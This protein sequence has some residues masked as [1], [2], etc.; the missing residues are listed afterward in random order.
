MFKHSDKIVLGVDVGGS[1]ISSALVNVKGEVLLETLCKKTVN[2]QVKNSKIIIDQW[3]QTIEETL[4]HLKEKELRGIGVAMPGPFDYENGISLFDGVGKYESLYGINI[5][6]VISNRLNLPAN[7]PLV[8]R[9]DADCFGLGEATTGEGASYKNIIAITLGTGFG[10]AFI[11]E[12]K[13]VKQGSSV[14]EKGYLYN[15]PYKDGIA[16]DYVSARW[17]IKKYLGLSIST[18]VT[19]EVKEIANA[20]IMHNDFHA[21]EVFEIYGKSIAHCLAPWIKSFK[22]EC[23]VIGGSIC[24]SSRLFLPALIAELRAHYDIDINVKISQKMELSAIAGA[25]DL[26][27]I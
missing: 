11:K 15:A 18:T 8:F 23:I 27:E 10:T 3:V 24:R 5:K 12:R 2:T 25:A 1:H 9:N 16:E 13:L 17:L 6:E 14:P 4:L 26:I 22:A 7:F 20:A 21:K 19:G